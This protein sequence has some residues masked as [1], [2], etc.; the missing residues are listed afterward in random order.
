M[1]LGQPRELVLAKVGPGL[2][3]RL[4]GH[5]VVPGGEMGFREDESRNDADVAEPDAIEVPDALHAR[6]GARKLVE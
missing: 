4:G 3:H 6:D 5:V 1:D 2:A